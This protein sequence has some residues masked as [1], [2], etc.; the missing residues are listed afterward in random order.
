MHISCTLNLTFVMVVNLDE[1]YIYINIIH[2]SI[3]DTS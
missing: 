2:P 3:L 1:Q